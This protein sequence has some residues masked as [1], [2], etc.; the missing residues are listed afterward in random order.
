MICGKWRKV[1]KI[2]KVMAGCHNGFSLYDS[3]GSI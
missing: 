1:E 3:Y 2:V